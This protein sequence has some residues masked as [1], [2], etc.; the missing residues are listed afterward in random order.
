MDTSTAQKDRHGTFMSTILVT[1]E[2][3]LP[4]IL[5]RIQMLSLTNVDTI[6]LRVHY[7]HQLDSVGQMTGVHILSQFNKELGSTFL[8]LLLSMTI[9]C[10]I[11][12]IQKTSMLHRLLI[13]TV[14]LVLLLILTQILFQT[15]YTVSFYSW[16]LQKQSNT[17]LRLQQKVAIQ[18]H[19][20]TKL[21]TVIYKQPINNSDL[22]EL[23]YCQKFLTRTVMMQT[24]WL[25]SII[26]AQAGLRC[27][28]MRQRLIQTW[29]VRISLSE[30]TL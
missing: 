10:L 25:M 20:S 4:G 18:H 19:G 7:T 30:S 28:T 24:S 5:S 26:V 1:I 9:L 6:L 27:Q 3:I 11:T 2:S 15:V 14:S 16:F 12:S 21:R 8:S 17:I 23:L 13:S 29:I 22:Q